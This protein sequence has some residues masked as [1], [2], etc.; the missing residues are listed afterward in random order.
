MERTL[1]PGS[2]GSIER[3]LLVCPAFAVRDFSLSFLNFI[4][5]RPPAQLTVVVHESAA[6]TVRSWL[7]GLEATII[8][9]PDDASL[10]MWAQDAFL[11]T[12][13]GLLVKPETYGDVQDQ[14]IADILGLP[15]VTAPLQFQGGNV[16][17]GDDFVLVGADCA[18]KSGAGFCDAFRRHIDSRREIHVL[19]S[20][21]PIPLQSERTGILDG[22]KWREIRY[23]KSLKG[24]EQPIFHLDLFVT[25]LGGRRLLVGDPALAATLLGHDPYPHALQEAF[26]DTAEQLRDLGFEVTRNPLPLVYMDEPEERLRTWYFASSNNALVSGKTV[27]L[28]KFGYA[29]WA[30]L[31]ATDEANSQI[32]TELGFNVVYIDGCR[33]LA[34]NL[35]GIHCLAK[36]LERS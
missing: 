31:A 1:L 2:S 29:G 3:L 11:V 33:A 27:W 36:C 34:E 25:L 17:A 24:T 19:G 10:S 20:R 22:V 7:A 5:R 30:T 28:P 21:V 15:T 6:A 13:S 4:A 26:D 18:R 9:A 12:E 35:G 16:L 32:W 23:Y 8:E 14:V